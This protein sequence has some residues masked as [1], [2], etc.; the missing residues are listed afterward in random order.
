[1]RQFRRR[2]LLEMGIAAGSYGA[3]GTQGACVFRISPGK[4]FRKKMIILGFDGMDP[5]VLEPLMAVGRMPAFRRL[6]SAGSYCRLGTSLPPQSP[7]AWSNFITG[8]DSGGHGIFDFIHRNPADYTPLLSTSRVT[9]AGRNLKMGDYVIPLTAGKTELLRQGRAFWQILEDHDVPATIVQIPSNF[10]PAPTR[11]RTLSGMGTPDVL[12]TYG[13]FH[14]YTT[15]HQELRPDIGGGRIRPVQIVDHAVEA[16]IEGPVNTFRVNSPPTSVPFRVFL[17]PTHAVAK[18]ILAGQEFMLKKGEWSSW[19]RLRFPMLP[20]IAVSGMCR[21][22]LKEVHPEFQLY[23]SAVHLDPSDPALPI[24]TPES[25]CRELESAIGPFFTK[26]LPADTMA[27]SHGVLDDREFLLQDDEML[28]ESLRLFEYELQHFESG[29]WFHYFSSTDQRQHMFLR[30]FDKSNPG[31]DPLLA[32]QCRR[33]VEDI[34]QRMDQVLARVLERV[35]Q[36]T[37]VLVMSDHGFTEFRREFNLNTWLLQ[38]GYMRLI[39]PG[40][41]EQAAFFQNTDW[42]NTRAYAL[43][44]NG[45]YLNLKGREGS[46]VVAG[47]AEKQ[48]LLELLRRDLENV[49]DPRSGEKVVRRVYLAQEA[50]HGPLSGSGP[51]LIVGY[52]RGY[53]AS[54]AS[55]LGRMPRRLLTD[56]EDK[57]GGDHCM[58]PSVVP[59]ILLV[60]RK[61]RDQAPNLCDLTA[62][63]LALF[64][65]EKLP[66]MIGQNFLEGN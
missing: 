54:S 37:V 36:D 24:S 27:V 59:G 41:Q 53:R 23:V 52:N 16:S 28:A 44:F 34:Y 10:P 33:V 39:E 62:S 26:G 5:G 17:D 55:A 47:G 60:N 35:D 29:V 15:R 4:Q 66:G 56:N 43:G 9:A 21:F 3:W 50:Y 46:G 48:A 14:L 19:T 12:G 20:F 57:W 7:V 65:I 64:G 58:D 18:I 49:R 11:Q 38:N 22:Y 25:Y 13:I 6:A 8:M 1:M 45:L 61:V 2:K 32:D 31:Y 51:D 40:N 63:I 42:E 30:S